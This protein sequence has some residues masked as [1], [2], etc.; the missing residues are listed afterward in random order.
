MHL[1][2][3]I[4]HSPRPMRTLNHWRGAMQ[5]LYR[6]KAPK[7]ALT[8][9]SLAF[10]A[11]VLVLLLYRD[12]QALTNFQWNIHWL[13]L[14]GALLCSVICMVWAAL[15]WG[16]I[17]AAFGSRVTSAQHI[18]CY[19]LSQLVKRL[20]GTIWYVASRGYLYQEYGEPLRLVTMASGLEF[21]LLFVSGAFITLLLSVFALPTPYQ[22][23]QALLL[24]V[25]VVGILFIQPRTIRW[26][27]LKLKM[28]ETPT[29]RRSVIWGWLIA[30]LLLWFAGGIMYFGLLNVFVSVDSVHLFY[31][32]ASW[33][34][35]G[36]LSF[37]VFFYLRT[38]V[39]MRLA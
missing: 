38:S 2:Q 28:S 35:V 9:L 29:L 17:M 31:I 21:V 10:A 11:I 8:L 24:V 5:Q 39:L 14:G 25:L 13:P 23:T 3:R 36:T 12:R 4:M 33:C 7:L 15:L 32:V 19:A 16:R 1:L 37:F 20:P 22:S 34:L 27:L 30:Y 6:A 26:L 18:R